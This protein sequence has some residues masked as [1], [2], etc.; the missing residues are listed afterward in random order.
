MLELGDGLANALHSTKS[1][2][3]HDVCTSARHRV[4]SWDQQLRS[5]KKESSSPLGTNATME[6][7]TPL[8]SL[9]GL[10][11]R[12]QCDTNGFINMTKTSLSMPGT[13][14][15]ASAELCSRLRNGNIHSRPYCSI[16]VST[17]RN[18]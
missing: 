1:E 16:L 12:T 8:R 9:P 11:Q 6:A 13:G 14:S 7:V 3:L 5:R 15:G 17:A 18:T 2:R 10:A 4:T